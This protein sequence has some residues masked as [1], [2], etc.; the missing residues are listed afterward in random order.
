MYIEEKKNTIQT[1]MEPNLN[2][3]PCN[4]ENIYIHVILRKSWVIH[5]EK[6]PNQTSHPK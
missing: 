1:N 6:V 3:N 2:P 5:V 4:Q